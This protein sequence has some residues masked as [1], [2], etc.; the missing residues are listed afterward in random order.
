MSRAVIFRS[1]EKY[2][3]LALRRRHW[4]LLGVAFTVLG[5]IAWMASSVAGL[6]DWWLHG[7]WCIAG[8]AI[9]TPVL[10]KVLTR[11]FGIV[12]SD[13]LVMFVAA[14]AL[15]FLFGASF[16]AFGPEE[17]IARS[18]SYYH[19]DAPDGLRADAVNGAGFGIALIV[20]GIS[21]RGWFYRRA[22]RIA[23]LASRIRPVTVMLSLIA[24]GS[25]ALL[26]TLLYDFGF[27]Q[28]IVSGVVRTA[29]NFV[30]VAV[31]LGASY[32]GPR[33]FSMRLTAILLVLGLS[34]T[35][36]LL[37]NKAQVLISFA[38]LVAGFS[39][40]HRARII[41]PTGLFVMAM[42]YFAISGVV[43][44]GRNTLGH[45]A[46]ATLSV[47]WATVKEGFAA[48]RARD[49][50]AETSPW[51]RLSYVTAQGAGMHF[52]GAGMGGDDLKVAPWV[53]I[54]RMIAP[55]KPILTNSPVDFH[56]KITG[57]QETSSTGQGVFSSGYYNAGWGGM[58][59]AAVV[60][61]WILAQTSAVAS[62]VLEARALILLPFAL[63]GVYI[64]FRIDGHFVT[65]YLGAFVF[66]LYPL[67]ASSIVVGVAK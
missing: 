54:P 65:D 10:F 4:I 23:V 51:G 1:S 33:A 28:G 12:L 11:G 5:L 53:F 61:G 22:S 40:V 47:R 56:Y 48:K 15:Y 26:Y 39:L 14:F 59:L 64:A 9:L 7:A 45:D 37:F 55:N 19:V 30:F 60:C 62:A 58:I 52:F 63:Y 42:V 20:A 43:A 24:F 17:A 36:I 57:R 3:G 13:H 35:G 25:V 32:R 2:L 29:S 46:G 41:L 38:A 44:Y 27:R 21:P 34:T 6:N 50:L 16:M 67:V 31:F 66:I 49:E 8:L 18:L